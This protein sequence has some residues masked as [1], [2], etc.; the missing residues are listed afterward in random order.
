MV[1]SGT[2][3]IG[4]TLYM[5]VG[6]GEELNHAFALWSLVLAMRPIYCDQSFVPQTP[7]EL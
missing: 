6:S 5:Y 1:E 7:M 3:F 4:N 2:Q